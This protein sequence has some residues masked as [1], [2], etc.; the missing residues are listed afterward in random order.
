VRLVEPI[1]VA[2]AKCTD[3]NGFSAGIRLGKDYLKNRGAETSI[4]MRRANV[5]M[6]EEQP[7]EARPHD[8][9]SDAPAAVND[10][11]CELW[12]EGIQKP[13]ACALRIETADALQTLAHGL[14]AQCG[15]EVG[16]ARSDSVERDDWGC[17]GGI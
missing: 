15:Q 12:F 6:L 4:L 14:D 11:T 5:Q 10:R 16:V 17:Q 13:R 3:S 8:Y 2:S 9:Q 7:V 1:G